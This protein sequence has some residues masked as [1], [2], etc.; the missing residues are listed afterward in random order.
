MASIL[1]WPRIWFDIIF[2]PEE[3]AS[4]LKKEKPKLVDG[5][6]SIGFC[7]LLIGFIAFLLSALL[8]LLGLVTGADIAG[9]L[10]GL[11]ILFGIFV[12]GFPIFMIILLL[13]LT[14]VLKIS[15]IILKG[16]G[17]FGE[18]CGVLGVVGST[19]MIIMVLVYGFVLISSMLVGVATAILGFASIA[20][21]Y[22]VMGVAY[23]ISMPLAYI[24]TAFTFDLMA[25][26][27]GVSIYRS[28]AILG[29]MAGIIAFIMML[30]FSAI[31]FLFAGA[32]S[33][34]A[35]GYY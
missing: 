3:T 27:E 22:I 8:G 23:L 14:V 32:M 35:G 34:F 15:S 11:L 9:S 18:E 29:L 7:S 2:R 1:K 6:I 24:V 17:S 25:D 16:K 4:L 20:L 19:Y 28:G 12:I 21:I 26:V 10:I 30:G 33:M 5:I 13:I 31:M